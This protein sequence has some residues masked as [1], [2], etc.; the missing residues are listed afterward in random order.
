MTYEVTDHATSWHEDA[1]EMR[2]GGHTYREIA[3][4]MGCSIGHATIIAGSVQMS[5]EG[6]RRHRDHVSRINSLN[7][8]I[9]PTRKRDDAIR[10]GYALG[11]PVRVIAEALGVTRNVV[12][13]RAYRLGLTHASAR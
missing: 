12:I 10:H 13:G 11:T 8:K 4:A 2:R 1:R 9:K 7:T 5:F 3:E 6:F